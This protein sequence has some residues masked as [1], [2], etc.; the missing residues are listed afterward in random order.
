VEHRKVTLLGYATVILKTLDYTGKGC[1]GQIL[2]YC[3]TL[4]QAPALLTNVSL[5]RKGLS[6]TVENIRK[7]SPLRFYGIGSCA[8]FMFLI[9]QN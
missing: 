4:M 7:L 6:W 5:G 8:K 1:K 2:A 9:E 3:L